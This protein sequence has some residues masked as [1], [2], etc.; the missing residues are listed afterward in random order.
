MLV[1]KPFGLKSEVRNMKSEVNTS[2]KL[3]QSQG[4]A[5]VGFPRSL[6]RPLVFKDEKKLKNIQVLNPLVKTRGKTS[7][8]ESSC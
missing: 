6:C 7:S 8:I 2:P 5:C 1:T 3:V 4:R